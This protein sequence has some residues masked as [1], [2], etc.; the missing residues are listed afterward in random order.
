MTV[1]KSAQSAE[2]RD[3]RHFCVLQAYLINF[4]DSFSL[5]KELGLISILDFTMTFYLSYEWMS[6]CELL[7]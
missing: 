3:L 6:L 2:L 4:R 7:C 5:L 1:P